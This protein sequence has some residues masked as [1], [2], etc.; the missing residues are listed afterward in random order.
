[1]RSRAHTRKFS[2]ANCSMTDVLH[3]W[4]LHCQVGLNMD[5]MLSSIRHYVARN[6]LMHA[7]LTALI[8][9]NKFATLAKRLHDDY[10]NIPHLVFSLEGIFSSLMLHLIQAIIDSCFDR[11]PD[12][13][14]D[15]EA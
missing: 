9:D 14:E 5:D 1:M 13:P 3:T 12:Y 11:D 10:C 6:K 4:P 15:Y 2:E 7:N 8:K